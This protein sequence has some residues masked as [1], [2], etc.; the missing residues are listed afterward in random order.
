MDTITIERR[1]CGPST[2][3]NGG[4]TCGRV[5][6][7]ITG[8]AEVTLRKPPPLDKPMRLQRDADGVRLMDDDTVVADAR[9]VELELD[10]PPAPSLDAARDA[11]RNYRGH[12]EHAFPDC[13]VCGPGRADGDGLRIF[14]GPLAGTDRVASTWTPDDGLGDADGFVRPEFIWAS[15]DCAGSWAPEPRP[16]GPIVL[17]RFADM[18][19]AVD[20]IGSELVWRGRTA[21]PP[22]R[23]ASMTVAGE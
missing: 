8:D 6:A 15:I 11:E 16:A 1:Y 19:L 20:R 9:P 14:T 12:R 23:I 17:G 3:G 21:A 7:A 22:V 18:L 5:A 4:Y 10:V 2:S 13:F